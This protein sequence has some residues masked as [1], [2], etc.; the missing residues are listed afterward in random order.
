MPAIRRDLIIEQ[1]TTWTHGFQVS[2]DGTPITTDW[3]VRSQ[4]RE[5]RD[6]TT[7]LHEWSTAIGNGAVTAGVVMLT[8]LPEV[9]TAWTWRYGYYDVEI[10]SPAGVVLRVSSGTVAVSVEVTR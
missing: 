8:V 7:V 5:R 3:T 6:A 2:V 1:G 4:V 10:V 9:S